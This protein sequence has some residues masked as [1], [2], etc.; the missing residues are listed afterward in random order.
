MITLG[1]VLLLTISAVF[2]QTDQN[3]IR[4]YEEANEKQL[5][6][7]NDLYSSKEEISYG[8]YIETVFPDSLQYIPIEA[9]EEFNKITMT[10]DAKDSKEETK[11]TKGWDWHQVGHAS[12]LDTSPANFIQYESGSK[13]W[14]P[15]PGCPIPHMSVNS[16]LERN[17]TIEASVL[18]YD[19]NIGEIVAEGAWHKTS[20]SYKTIGHHSGIYPSGCTPPS[21]YTTTQ[22]SVQT[23]P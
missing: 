8:K 3:S 1:L 4:Y 16:N 21:Y 9:L 15:Y 11:G 7:I 6:I 12:K 19:D 23:V 18:V 20:G 14:I 17:G 10:W 2:A 13:V 5:Q 22:T